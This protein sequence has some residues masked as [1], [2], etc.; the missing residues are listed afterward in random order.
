[1]TELSEAPPV[2][3]DPVQ[4]LVRS[5]AD[6]VEPLIESRPSLTLTPR[7]ATDDED[8]TAYD[9]PDR[10]VGRRGF[11]WSA[12]VQVLAVSA[13]A[14]AYDV[15]RAGN[16][17]VSVALVALVLAITVRERETQGRLGG[18][19]TAA[20]VQDLFVGYAAVSLAVA[21][22]ALGSAAL[23]Q[24]AL[25]F[26]AGGAVLGGTSYVRQRSGAPVRV[27]VVGD[28]PAVSRA[29]MQWGASSR[30]DVVG[31]V[32]SDHR[33]DD[34]HPTS[35]V[36]VPTVA[37]VEETLAHLRRCRA[38]VVLVSPGSGLSGSDVRRLTWELEGTGAELGVLGLVDHAA[39]HR[40]RPV[41]VDGGT[42]LEVLPT[43][44][45]RAVRITKNVVDRVLGT[46]LLLVALPL[47]GLL[48]LAVRWD[49]PGP[50][51]YRQ[52]RIGRDGARFTLYKLRSM[53]LHADRELPALAGLNEADGPLFKIHDD[54]R[55]TRVGRVLRR[56]SLDELPQLINVVRGEM[57]LVGPRPALPAEVA[58]YDDVELRRLHVLPGV[59][60]LWQVSG[61][62]DLGWDS[63]MALD[64]RYADNWRLRGDASILARTLGAVVR[65]RGAY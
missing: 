63:G 40:V 54:P 38:E 33:A 10:L 16:P 31:G 17:A 64:L 43:R 62:S 12:L 14:V 35:V 47:I 5:V 60:G 6:T 56:T 32:L 58:C 2:V 24:A 44:P 53:H 51:V 28:R 13:T 26:V 1:M 50:A 15:L 61:R 36:G 52:T 57:S 23:P 25:I 41:Q 20:S 46:V 55:V 11:P 4:W 3:A 42:V 65:R 48:V 7:P 29:A 21:V 39:P 45:S 34:D 37:G 9:A 59:T 18:A 19:R 30:V 22:G 8:D 49:T 27:L